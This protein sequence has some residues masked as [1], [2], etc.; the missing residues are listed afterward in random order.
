MAGVMDIIKKRRSVR[1]YTGEPVAKEKIERIIEAANHAP[2]AGNAYTWKIAVVQD[3]GLIRK[4][5]SVSPG[6]LGR[7]AAILALCNDRKKAIETM[8]S[9]GG[10]LF[11]FMDVAHAA[12]NICLM[13]AELGIGSCCIMSFNQDAVGA[14]LEIPPQY[15]VDY[16]VALGYQDRDP[17][18]PKKRSVEEAVLSWT[19]G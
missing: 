6:M 15:R 11:R 17:V 4:I 16:L 1:S 3:G 10:E 9:K 18:A 14:L 13:G 8:G 7:P 19:G 12:Q 2:S 5:Q